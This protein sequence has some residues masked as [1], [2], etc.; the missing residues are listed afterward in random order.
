MAESTDNVTASLGLLASDGPGIRPRPAI[1]PA[2]RSGG[3]AGPGV[4]ADGRDAA[5]AG[6][7]GVPADAAREQATAAELDLVR[8]AQ[9]GDDVAFGQLVESNRRAVYRAAYAALG[10]AADADDVA[11]DTFVTVYRKLGGFRGDASFRTWLLSIAWRKA[12]DRRR[13]VTRWL[14]MTVS[15][16]AA[17]EDGPDSIERLASGARSQEQDVAADELQRR[18][19]QLIRTLP[20]KHRDALLLA[21]SGDHTYDQIAKMLGIPLGTVKWRVA[22]ARRVLKRKLVAMGYGND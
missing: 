7:P 9:A 14:R 22:E 15:P 3:E 11:Q 10:S 12:L 6:D 21:S 19:R 20:R 5:P 17:Q 4:S 1:P 13:S 16:G 2:P 8:R 18:V